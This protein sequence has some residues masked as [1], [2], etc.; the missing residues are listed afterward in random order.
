M[1][2]P[3]GVLTK[4]DT[5][6]P[7]EEGAWLSIL[8]GQRHPLHHG[9]YMTKQP[10]TKELLEKLSWEA[11]RE[12]EKEYF[13]TTPIWAKSSATNRLGTANLTK[14]LSRLLSGLIDQTYV[15]SSGP[16]AMYC[17]AGAD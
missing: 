3:I 2:P 16:G 1:L 7:G 4:P 10:A 15:L 11:A 12:R 8:E 5:L 14:N 6:Q 13:D 9:Y 17:L